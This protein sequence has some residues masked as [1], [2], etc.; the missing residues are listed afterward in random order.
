L[1]WVQNNYPWDNQCRADTKQNTFNAD[2][3]IRYY[4]IGGLSLN[5]DYV[6]TIRDSTDPTQDFYEN[7]FRMGLTYQYGLF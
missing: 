7:R 3:G 2:L 6:F 5:L 1:N 4:L